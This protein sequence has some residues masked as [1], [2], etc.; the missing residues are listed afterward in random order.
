MAYDFLGETGYEGAAW[1][2]SKNVPLDGG[3]PLSLLEHTGGAPLAAAVIRAK[4]DP[5]QFDEIVSWIDGARAI[6]VK[7]LKDEGR[8]APTA[9][10]A[11]DRAWRLRSERVP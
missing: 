3:K 8:R 6:A 10:G 4:N 9:F 11:G 7:S 2:W 5:T 1:D